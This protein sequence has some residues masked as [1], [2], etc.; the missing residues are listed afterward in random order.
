MTA[1]A[2]WAAILA[3]GSPGAIAPDARTEAERERA[4][5]AIHRRAESVALG[6]AAASR[7]SVEL[8]AIGHAYLEEEET[9]RAM[10]LLTEAY[11]LDDQNGL[12]LS[13]LTL[14]HVRV[15][16]FESARFY[17][18]LAEERVANAP[19]EI[20]GVLGE[21][22]YSLNR[23]EDAVLAWSEFARFG[24][25]DPIQLRRL[26]RARDEL[27]LAR[28]Q[29]SFAADHFSIFA[30]PDVPE[31]MVRLAARDLEAAYGRESTF[32]GTQL[33][34]PQIVVLY[35]GRSYFS[36]VS[37]PDW[38]SGLFDGKIR[39]CVEPREG[40][41]R[42]LSAV[43]T[44]EL[45]HALIRQSSRDRAPGWLHEGL[46]QWW[47]GRRLPR[48]DIK[49]VLGG[50]ATQSMEGLEASFRRKL[51]RASARTSY[52]EALSLV[53]HLMAIRGEGVVACV[54]A[55]LAAGASF[56]DALYEETGLTPDEL[57]K[58][59]ETWAGI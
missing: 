4:I 32:F 13:E 40:A 43:L 16:D 9:G 55:N 30:D 59:W 31:E 3:L 23:L 12:V 37:V 1:L 39:V 18:R 56:P 33:P 22:Y 17:L 46:T 58:G 53:E 35:S 57:Y 25:Q 36:L 21:I 19:P 20:Y 51:D 10:E 29:R 26:L 49:S 50:K 8:G 28:G 11:G 54:L 34:S 5:T 47:E 6:T 14:A 7:L 38:V 45:A 27:A 24:G 2:V 15:G 42:A 41:D 52:A 48:R 44:H